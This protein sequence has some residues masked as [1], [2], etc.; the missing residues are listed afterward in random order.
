MLGP[1]LDPCWV[2]FWTHK[3]RAM[4]RQFLT[5]FWDHL[6]SHFGTHLDTFW[7]HFGELCVA[8]TASADIAKTIKNQWFFN[9]F[10]MSEVSENSEKPSRGEAA[11][12]LSA[13]LPNDIEIGPILVP[14]WL[15][16]WSQNG[17]R[18][19]L[20]F[21]LVFGLLFG[22]KLDPKMV[23]KRLQNWSQ[24]GVSCPDVLLEPQVGP[25][26]DPNWL[27]SLKMDPKWLPNGS[28]M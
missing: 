17:V 28:K 4:L 12:G 19:G 27:R 14:K 13:Q 18:K 2:L 8:S 16:N 3:S 9:D 26:M 1:I 11:P 20:K 21:A 5:P 24:N 10:A 23:P 15:Q 7:R 6:W 22:P 25:K